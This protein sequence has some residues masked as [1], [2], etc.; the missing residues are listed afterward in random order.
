MQRPLGGFETAAALTADAGA[1]NIV[2]VLRL[3][4]GPPP[5]RLQRAL[6][7]LQG[8]HPL[9]GAR[10]ERGRS[11]YRFVAGGAPP[12]RLRLA[13]RAAEQSWQAV[14]EDEVNRRLDPAL[15]PP[16]ACTYL[17]PAAAGD[18]CEIVLTLHHAMADGVSSVAL[19]DQLLTL[20][21]SDAGS[22]GP[23]ETVLPPPVE[24]LFPA[25]FRGFRGRARRLAFLLGQLGDEAAYRW[26]SRGSRKPPLHE[27]ARCRILPLQLSE[28]ATA[29]L[30]QRSRQQKVTMAGALSAALLLAVH[31]HLYAGRPLPLRYFTFADLRPYL[32]PPPPRERLAGYVAPLRYTVD[33]GPGRDFWGL[34]RQVSE[35][36]YRS[37]RR[38]DKF[39]AVGLMPALMQALL[40]RRSFRMGTTAVSY[41]G[42][43]P[44]PARYG[45]IAL[46]GVHAFVSNIPLGPEYTAH[47]KLFAD[48]LWLDILYLDADM[49]APLARSLG[50]EV[51]RMLEDAAKGG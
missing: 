3:A 36:I 28:P 38:G 41:T 34:A 19:L 39:P 1:L 16:L 25:P 15:E 17:P 45:A 40:A 33:V 23:G 2:I 27:S 12:I 51:V 30:V 32:D 20:C 44:L 24:E 6:A 26:R 29:G 31:R 47:V 14:A 18:E 21:V 9:L 43:L 37:A 22:L 50:T 8:H 46:T 13:E 49:D 48:R 10:L 11:G 7:E 5:E 42:A 35:Q 4:G